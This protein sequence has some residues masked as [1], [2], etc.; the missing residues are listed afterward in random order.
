MIF[1]CLKRVNG[2]IFCVYSHCRADFQGPRGSFA[3]PDLE[4]LQSISREGRG[5]HY[6]LDLG[7]G[8]KVIDV[9]RALFE[10]GVGT[11]SSPLHLPMRLLVVVRPLFG[12]S[13]VKSQEGLSPLLRESTL[14]LDG[15]VLFLLALGLGLP[16]IGEIYVEG[17]LGVHLP[18][19][20]GD[21]PHAYFFVDRQHLAQLS[22]GM[23]VQH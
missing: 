5:A 17:F 1:Y 23:Q 13:I 9:H 3:G 20:L 4:D 6:L 10:R 15:L 11:K 14:I 16:E 12:I 18:F 22:L 2:S 21:P 8:P 7:L 19:C